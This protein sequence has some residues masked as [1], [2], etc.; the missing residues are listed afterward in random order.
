MN[1]NRQNRAEQIL[2]EESSAARRALQEAMQSMLVRCQRV[3]DQDPDL[4][5]MA[6]IAHLGQLLAFS[7]MCCAAY[8]DR[9]ALEIAAATA[10]TTPPP[11][12]AKN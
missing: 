9:A 12:S 5:D 6:T 3:S 10:I 4:A 8:P 11:P 2:N 1:K 7:R